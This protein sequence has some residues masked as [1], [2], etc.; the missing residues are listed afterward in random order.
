LSSIS[1]ATGKKV[2]GML[3][4]AA[5]GLDLAAMGGEGPNSVYGELKLSEKLADELQFSRSEANHYRELLEESNY[6]KARFQKENNELKAE[7]AKHKKSF[8]QLKK[9]TQQITKHVNC[10]EINSQ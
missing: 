1:G 2:K 3:N 7:L 4:A 10:S 8:S 5:G 9:E 6:H